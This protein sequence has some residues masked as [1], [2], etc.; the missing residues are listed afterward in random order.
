MRQRDGRASNGFEGEDMART[1]VSKGKGRERARA[2]ATNDGDAATR[3]DE[4]PTTPNNAPTPD[5]RLSDPALARVEQALR[6]AAAGDFSV[7]LPARHKNAIGGLEAAYN[8]LAARNAALEA[9]LVRV[10]QIIGREGRM[11]ERALRAPKAPGGARST[12]S[13][14]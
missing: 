5:P 14:A 10:G 12:P 9:E 6:A 3:G 7:R 13:T 4:A 2:R 11:T 8:E 1:A